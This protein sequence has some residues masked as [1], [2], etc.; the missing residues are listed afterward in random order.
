MRNLAPSEKKV[1]TS[2]FLADKLSR[3]SLSESLGLTGAAVTL[4]CQDLLNEN[5][6]KENGYFSTGKAGRRERYLSLNENAY[7]LVGLDCRRHSFVV[8]LTSLNGSLLSSER[9]LDLAEAVAYLRKHAPLLPPYLGIGVTIRGY[10]TESKFF[11]EHP[12]FPS[13]L[14][15][16]AC[17]VHYLNNVESLAS[18]HALLHPEEQ[19]FLLLKYG[20]G[21]GS[22]IFIAGK[23]LKSNE[24]VSS[25][26]G[27]WYL[28]PGLRFE[29]A[30]SFE[31]LLG[32]DYEEKEGA[33]ALLG[34]PK[35]L[36]ECLHV[37]A[38]SLVNADYLLALD[39]IILSG[40]LLS[41]Q[42]VLE[43]LLQ[44]IHAIEAD[45]DSSKLVI[46]K[47]YESI[48][49]RKGSLQVFAD[50]FLF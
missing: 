15:E 6:I 41:T 47:D 36:Q 39:K 2:L 24:G 19:N 7:T 28:R 42:G 30:I 8:L 35:A 11:L 27:H 22:S 37:I 31:A 1:M 25:E 33:G 18:I 3:K 21:V 5:L 43:Q 48:N 38:F 46:Y 17:P 26:I 45:F 10:S 49:E 12:E 29:D 32:Q 23:P 44:Q 13:A 14:A 50:S 4:S 34:N 9:F 40:V 20:P 16:F